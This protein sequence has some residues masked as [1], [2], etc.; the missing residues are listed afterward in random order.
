MPL[1]FRDDWLV[2]VGGVT[3]VVLRVAPLPEVAIYPA[4]HA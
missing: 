4:K 1:G 2:D 3:A